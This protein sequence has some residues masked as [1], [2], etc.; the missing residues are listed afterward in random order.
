MDEKKK[1]ICLFPPSLLKKVASKRPTELHTQIA[2]LVSQQFEQEL[3]RAYPAQLSRRDIRVRAAHAMF[4]SFLNGMAYAR[5][6]HD[7]PATEKEMKEYLESFGI[8]APR[9]KENPLKDEDDEEEDPLY[10][11]MD[12]DEGELPDTPSSHDV[13]S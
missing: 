5:L 8:E 7:E 4:E 2:L 11:A 6:F 3:T 9:L 1:Q 10:D 12:D 13:P